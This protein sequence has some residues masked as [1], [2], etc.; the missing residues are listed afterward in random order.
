MDYLRQFA[1][2]LEANKMEPIEA[3]PALVAIASSPPAGEVT[4]FGLKRAVDDLLRRASPD[5]DVIMFV[6]DVAIFEAEFLSPH[7]FI[8]RGVNRDGYFTN[9]VSHYAQVMARIIYRPKQGP[10]RIVTQF[11]SIGDL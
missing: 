8:F 5:H 9:I 2:A 11:T 7:T 10:N 6:S 3:R 1:C 4:W